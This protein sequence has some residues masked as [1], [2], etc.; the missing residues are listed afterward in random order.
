MVWYVSIS[1]G[2][3]SDRIGGENEAWE[4]SGLQNHAPSHARDMQL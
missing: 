2:L 4:F 3:I 1:F